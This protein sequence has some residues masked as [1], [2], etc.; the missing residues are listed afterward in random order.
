MTAVTNGKNIFVY[1]NGDVNFQCKRIVVN[2]RQVKN[3][4]SFIELMTAQIKAKNGGAI[5][6]VFTP[7]GRTKVT[8][9]EK[10][11]NNHFYVAAGV[12]S[13][14]RHEYNKIS[15]ITN[16]R[17]RTIKLPPIQPV[18]HSRLKVSARCRRA[19]ISV[20][21]KVI[22]VFRNGDANSPAVKILFTKF[23]LKNYDVVLNEVTR[24]VNILTGAVWKLHA[25]D[26]RQLQGPEE[27]EDH[28][29]YVACG[30]EAFKKVPYP[31]DGEIISPRA[32]RPTMKRRITRPP[33]KPKPPRPKPDQEAESP[34]TSKPDSK[35]AP[36]PPTMAPKPPKK[37]KSEKTP[38][39]REAEEVFH[40]KPMMVKRS[41]EKEHKDSLDFSDDPNGVFKAKEERDETQGA[42]EVQETRETVV[43]L[44][45]D[46]VAAEEIEDEEDLANANQDPIPQEAFQEAP[47]PPQDLG[48]DPDQEAVNQY[49]ADTRD[50]VPEEIPAALEVTNDGGA[51]AAGDDDGVVPEDIPTAPPGDDENGV[52]GRDGVDEVQEE[53]PAVPIENS[54]VAPNDSVEEIQEDLPLPPADNVDDGL[55]DEVD[56]EISEE[57]PPPDPHGHD[58]AHEINT[59]DVAKV[60]EAEQSPASPA[61]DVVPDDNIGDATEQPE[62]LAPSALADVIKDDAASRDVRLEEESVPTQVAN[63]A[64]DGGGVDVEVEEDINLPPVENLEGNPSIVGD[65]E[66][67]QEIPPSPPQSGGN[68]IGGSAG[69]EVQEALPTNPDD[70]VLPESR[71]S[72][73]AGNPGD[74]S[75]EIQ[76][77]A[78]PADDYD[79]PLVQRSPVEL[80]DDLVA[81]LSAVN[82]DGDPDDDQGNPA[83]VAD[84][85]PPATTD[86]EG[87]GESALPER[88]DSPAVVDDDVNLGDDQD[89]APEVSEEIPPASADHE[90]AEEA[91]L[92]EIDGAL[93]N[94]DLGD[95]QDD[96]PEVAEEIPQATAG[97]GGGDED[98]LPERDD[99]PSAVDNNG[100]L[101]DDQDNAPEVSEEIPPAT[102]DVED[103]G[104]VALPERDGA[105]SS[106]DL[107]DGQDNAPE[108]AEEIPPATPYEGGGGEDALPQRDD[109]PSAVDGNLGDGQDNTPGVAEEIPPA[110]PVDGGSGEDALPQRDD[111]PLAVDNDDNLGDGPA[112]APEVAEEIPPA[113]P[114]EGG[115][116]EDAL[117][118]RDDAPSAVDNDDNL[119]D[120]QAN[121]PE[122]AEEIPP[123]TADGGGG[124]GD[125]LPE[126]DDAPSAVDNDHNLGDGQDD[127]PKV[128]E[129]IPPANADG[130]EGED[131]LPERNDGLGDSNDSGVDDGVN[132]DALAG[133]SRGGSGVEG[134]EGGAPEASQSPGREDGEEEQ[135]SAIE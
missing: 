110:T 14:K 117:P 106:G 17:S 39:Q 108:V 2:P 103:A 70:G 32:I 46:Q 76:E 60:A 40:S 133:V 127:A 54:N 88:V 126:R 122:V 50:E 55:G 7:T 44:P 98:A 9:L 87:A 71:Q 45:I 64:P 107:G 112:N 43:D 48:Q 21:S 12:E 119:G 4:D 75:D 101:G 116:D 77:E 113:T 102:A 49:E 11:E 35:E 79:A 121:A 132:G 56:E 8:A 68:D 28:Q 25:L 89:N 23:M 93:S 33:L 59:D 29:F 114:Y 85:I 5:R 66:V 42:T 13:F 27:F 3:W 51:D 36:K 37:K 123:A 130:G 115:G 105:L 84:E 65:S 57:L 100:T 129:D 15:G 31:K 34:K 72:P 58:D 128:V 125:A 92:P 1:R 95:G 73:P 111:A 16:H 120:G 52:D 90:D 91:A 22:Y 10:I 30:R 62:D 82:N 47:A 78:L 67:P 6:R 99:A 41:R 94:G 104:E 81:A 131:A 61:G 96:A 83:E 74:A 109:A 18:K 38:E 63:V 97:G 69:D 118:E 86:G 80:S 135:V 19:A 20:G 134:V 124:G 26:G 24:K 53:L